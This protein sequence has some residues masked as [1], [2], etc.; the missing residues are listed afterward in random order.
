MTLEQWAIEYGVTYQALHA[1]RALMGAVDQPEPPLDAPPHTEAYVQALVRLEAPRYGCT[2]WRNN[3][4][5]LTDDRGVPVRYGLANDSAKF[6][7]VFKTGDLVGIR[8]VLIRPE[9][10]GTIFGRFVMRECKKPGWKYC[11]D[12]HESAQ[13]AAIQ[14]VN[15]KGGDAAFCTG[16]GTL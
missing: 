16:E 13:L 7:K 2:L 5:A 9:H 6:N 14:F 8:P 12:A 11:G 4:G 3:V 10:V 1:L 15:A